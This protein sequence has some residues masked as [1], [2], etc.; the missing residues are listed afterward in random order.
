M[1]ETRKRK[2][3]MVAMRFCQTEHA[4]IKHKADKAKMSFTEFVTAASLSKPIVI[5]E[6]LDEVLR[7]QRAIG[8][9]LNQITTLCNM[10]KIRV[11]NL[12]EIKTGFSAI[13]DKLSELL[14][15][16]M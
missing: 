12:A 13:T 8:R 1:I 10:G 4:A 7:E 6:G 2:D 3:K 14:Q 5:I 15:R 9:N 11:P 16:Y